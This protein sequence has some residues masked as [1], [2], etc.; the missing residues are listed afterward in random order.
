MG[1]M[2]RRPLRQQKA[3][4][5]EHD[6]AHSKQNSLQGPSARQ[7]KIAETAR[8]RP[9]QEPRLPLQV[10]PRGLLTAFVPGPA[11]WEPLMPLVRRLVRTYGTLDFA[12]DKVKST[13]VSSKGEFF[14]MPDRKPVFGAAILAALT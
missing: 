3:G 13:A 14:S 4:A 12:A 6:H 1:A 2:V 7:S 11:V 8:A 10:H 5:V 9:L